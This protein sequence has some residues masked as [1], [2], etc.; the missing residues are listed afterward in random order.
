MA[1]EPKFEKVVTGTRKTLGSVQSQVECKFP[2]ADEVKKI[3]C[4]N[5]KANIT[6]VDVNGKEIVYSGFVN[7]QMIY[8]NGSYEPVSMDYTAEFKDRYQAEYDL[9]NS[10]ATVDIAVIDVNTM[11][12]ND[13]KVQAVLELKFDVIENNYITAL[14]DVQ[15][16]NY[17]VQK[18]L[19]NYSNYVS[20]IK[21]Q[22]ELINDIEIKDGISKVLS[23]CPSV[24]IE[25]VVPSDRFLTLNGGVYFDITYLTDNNMIRTT[26]ANFTFNQEIANDNLNENS[27]IQNCL[28]ILYNDIKVTTSIDTNSAIVNINLPLLYNGYIFESGSLE[29]VRD[30]YSTDYFNK[31]VIESVKT[32]NNFSNIVFN[33][34]LNGSI[35]I[36]DNDA[37]ID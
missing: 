17:F 31:V 11:L 9:K 14:V 7:F 13:I 1:F 23:V 19:F 10:V 32:L 4:S 20:M 29:I 22:F 33:D 5:A 3:V 8:L 36:Q 12:G 30:L 15:G 35:T 18:E 37:F 21:N 28:Q 26:S 6:N 25:K 34:R 2:A 24:Y 27:I 16:I